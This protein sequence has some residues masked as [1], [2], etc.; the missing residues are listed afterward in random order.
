MIVGSVE[1]FFIGDV[2]QLQNASNQESRKRVSGGILGYCAGTSPRKSKSGL[3]VLC[4]F[5]S[6]SHESPTRETRV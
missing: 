6:T 3:Q 4:C 2:A 5:T 1:V